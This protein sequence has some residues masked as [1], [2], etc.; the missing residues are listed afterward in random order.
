M[1]SILTWNITCPLNGTTTL[2]AAQIVEKSIYDGMNSTVDGLQ[3]VYVDNLCNETVAA[4]SPYPSGRRLQNAASNVTATVVVSTTCNGCENNM[5]QGANDALDAIIKDGSLTQSVQNNS[6]G[7]I[8]AAFEDNLVTT[9]TVI[10]NP[11]SAAPSKSPVTSSP[12]VP[13]STVSPVTTSPVTASPVNLAPTTARPTASK[14]SKNTKVGKDTPQP[15]AKSAK[16][17]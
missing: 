10:S 3:T 8:Q 11:P 13:S 14:S 4:H 6:A 15:T 1:K 16:L 9:S 17:V 5:A 7:A 2:E 12:V